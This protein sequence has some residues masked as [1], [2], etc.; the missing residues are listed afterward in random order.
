MSHANANC[1]GVADLFFGQLFR[2]AEVFWN[3]RSP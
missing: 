1:A 3:V 2:L